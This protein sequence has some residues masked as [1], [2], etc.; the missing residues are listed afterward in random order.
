MTLPYRLDDGLGAAARLGIVVLQTDETLEG[1]ARGILAGRDVALL[2]SRI[3]AH[4][5][6][7]PETL[8]TMEA[9][10]P[11]SA[12]LLP[13]GL[14]AIAY[15]CTSGATIIGPD[16]VEAILRARQPKART[17]DP[18]RAVTAALYALGAR[19][20]G[21]V[22][23]YQAQVAGPIE[24]YLAGQGIETARR[25]SFDQEDDWT[26]A[27]IVEPS[28]ADAL[29]SVA[30]DGGVDAL[31]ASCTNLR[32]F[33]IIEEVERDTGLPVVT[34]NLALLWHLLGIADVDARGWGP[35][36]LFGIRP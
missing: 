3:P 14:D 23:P 2:H 9:A 7:T 26:V 5:A 17:T 13:L 33:G 6:V 31:F 16:R 1:E 19:R 8:A 24:S 29:R 32:S 18:I 11:A 12:A 10:L 36:R 25:V 21:M 30:K 35:G 27:R 22:T 15:A 20:I 4:A 28:T 34:S